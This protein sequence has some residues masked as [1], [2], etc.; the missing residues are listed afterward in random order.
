MEKL[1][2]KQALEIIGQ[3][4]AHESLKLTQKEHLILIEAYRTIENELTPKKDEVLIPE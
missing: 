1:T 4:L 3:V 2:S